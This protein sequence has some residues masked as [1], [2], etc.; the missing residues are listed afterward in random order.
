MKRIIFILSI[1]SFAISSCSKLDLAPEDYYGSSNFWNKTAQV[2]AFM[3]GIHNH[4]RASSQSLLYF[5]LGEAR[6]GTSKYGIAITSSSLDLSSP[7]KDNDFTKDKA[8]L[9]NW[10]GLYGSLLQVNLF[11]K[12][13]EEGCAFLT[14]SERNYLLGQ[15]Y[16]I[17]AFFYFMLYRTWGGVPIVKEAESIYVSASEARKL[18]CPR[19]TPKQ[20]MDFIKED[21]NKS[22][23]YFGNDYSFKGTRAVWSKAATLMLKAEIYLWS[24]KVT[25][26]DQ[27]PDATDLQTAKDALTPLTGRFS[28]LSNFS[29][30]FDYD[31]KD[32]D[33][34][35]FTV[36]Y[37]EG[38]STNPGGNF[39]VGS[40]SLTGGNFY[41]DDGTRIAS[42]VLNMRAQ[43]GP[44]RHEYKFGLFESYDALDS[45]KKATFFDI[46]QR[47]TAMQLVD[48]GTLMLKGIGFVNSNNFRIF[49]SDMHVYRYA[50]V[51]LLMAEIENKQGNDPSGYINQIRQRA[52]GS[53]YNEALHGHTDAGF[54]ANELAILYE[55]DKEFVW[56]GKRWFDVVRMQDANGRALVFSAE[57]NYDSSDPVL[58]YETEAHKLLWPV[59]V[60]TL[61]NDPTLEQ[62]PGY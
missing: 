9:S 2:E 32:N 56:E 17:R 47:N 20:V 26:G 34:I 35:I 12:N 49:A 54:A 44:Q 53:N 7:V 39:L 58:N 29:D 45:R 55:R 43:G 40:P 62:T 24:T 38:E 11:I 42:D 30:I 61:S 46:Y 59:D 25:T 16:G 1:V 13:V 50:D 52:Y 60:N 31:N 5:T 19:S 14:D 3:L 15:A 6:G 27:S 36:R 51:L 41:L 10:G 37:S 4:V 21:V 18:Y 23:N 57:A 8:Q 28:L 48:Q 33:E 22:D